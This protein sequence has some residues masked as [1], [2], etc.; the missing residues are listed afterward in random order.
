MIILTLP[1]DTS[2]D[3]YRFNK[4]LNEDV[5]VKPVSDT[6]AHWDIQM[7]K[8]DYVNVTGMESLCNAICIAI[9]TRF[10]EL[11][12][13]D[14]YEG[15]GCRAHELIKANKSEMVRYKVELFVV[16]VLEKMRRVLSV[17]NVTVSDSD[18]HSYLINF[19]VTSIND[20]IVKGSVAL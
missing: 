9:M 15:F 6:G 1:V 5:Q 2:S 14:L 13:I 17:N 8:G 18:S 16:E 10:N 20:E 7:S 12:Y 4:T 3:D 11:D 19:N